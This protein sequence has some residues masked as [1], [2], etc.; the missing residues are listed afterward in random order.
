MIVVDVVNLLI[1]LFDLFIFT[2]YIYHLSS[3]I[4]IIKNTT[5]VIL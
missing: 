3:I 4:K 5:R 2:I 1:C